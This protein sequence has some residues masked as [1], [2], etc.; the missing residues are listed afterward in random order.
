MHVSADI[1]L[2]PIGVGESLSASI[3]AAI[4]VIEARGLAPRTHAHG[5]SVEGDLSVVLAAIE[6]AIAA[7][8]A[9]GAPRVSTAVKIS[10][11]TDRAQSDAEKV[12]SVERHLG[13]GKSSPGA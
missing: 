6:A 5:T 11:R 9:A 3:A 10:S 1:Q 8:H 4:R 12:A 2:I 13:R 7:V